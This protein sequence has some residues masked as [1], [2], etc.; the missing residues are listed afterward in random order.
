MSRVGDAGSAAAVALLVL[1]TAHG[2]DAFAFTSR[3]RLTVGQRHHHHEQQH[4]VEASDFRRSMASPAR[5][6][7]ATGSREMTMVSPSSP[8]TS[9][10]TGFPEPGPA[11]LV[12]ERDACGVGFIANPKGRVDHKVVERGLAALG[13]MEHRGACLADHV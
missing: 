11:W 4:Y 9:G 2:N 3:A 7:Q 8:Q 1:L 10:A 13:C 5:H 6:Y 12:D